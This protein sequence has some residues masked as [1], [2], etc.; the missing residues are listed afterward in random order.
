ML[1]G[2]SEAGAGERENTESIVRDTI[3]EK[4]GIELDGKDIKRS[5]RL[6]PHKNQ[7]AT[8]ATRMTPRPI[9][10][11]LQYFSKRQEIYGTKKML[12]NTG[13]TI[14]EN[15][16]R[17]RYD[18]YKKALLKFGKGNVWTM[19]GRIMVKIDGNKKSITTLNEFESL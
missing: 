7:R 8:R 16:T 10:F 19:E 12:K 2:I 17:F 11:R 4:L 15:L 13:I 5:H 9:I 1:H 14:T 6:G 3:K 18:L